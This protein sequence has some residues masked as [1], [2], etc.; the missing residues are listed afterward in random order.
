M[1]PLISSLVPF[2]SFA[3]PWALD[4]ES[5]LQVE[6][7][8][9]EFCRGAGGDVAVDLRVEQGD[10]GQEIVRCA[11]SL[12]AD[13][14]VL[15]THGLSGFDRW[16]LG[17]I[18]VKVVR[19]SPVPVL[20]IAPPGD[21]SFVPTTRFQRLLCPI[22]LSPAS[23]EALRW[24][25]LLAQPNQA[26]VTALHV[27]DWRPD[28]NAPHEADSDP[29]AY[30]RHLQH[31]ARQRVQAAVA[32]VEGLEAAADVVVCQGRS[33]EEILRFAG[34]VGS[35]LIVMGVH[36]SATHRLFFGSTAHRVVRESSCPVL[37]VRT[38]PGA[39]SNG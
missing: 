15:G 2:P 35:D 33:P 31:E 11:E 9:R 16:V 4:A 7:A 24:S 13:M 17:S 29:A 10:V 21:R 34:H 27:V 1:N 14:V 22:D 28:L 36:G 5:R 38:P 23:R 37:T 30:R 39:T 20:T 26:R 6:G 3:D 25:A 12:P 19:T 18:A 8:L 32:E